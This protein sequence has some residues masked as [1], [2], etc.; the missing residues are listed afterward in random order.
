[1]PIDSDPRALAISIDDRCLL[2]AD[3]PHLVEIDADTTPL[4][5]RSRGGKQK[6]LKHPGAGRSC[7]S[8]FS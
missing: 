6:I 8:V 1:V 4:A 2:V 7:V 3:H 5:S